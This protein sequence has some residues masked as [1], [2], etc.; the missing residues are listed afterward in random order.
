MHRRTRAEVPFTAQQMFDLVA[1]VESYPEFLPYCV[2]LR[3]V[4]DDVDEAGV[5]ALCADMIVAFQVFREKFRSR[6]TLD[7]P[8]LR[9]DVDY[10]D[11]PFRQLCNIWRFE[12]L[13][14]GGSMIDFEIEFEFRSLLMQSTANAVFERAFA[15][16]SDA[17]VARAYDVYP[18]GDA[19]SA[20]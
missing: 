3:V 10:V 5:G 11:G 7:R 2:A 8:S 13:V 20:E 18:N 6:A 12:N 1:D 15:K 17:F 19:L 16:M 4:S 9:I 14:E